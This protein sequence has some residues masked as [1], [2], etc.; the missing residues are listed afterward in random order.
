[1]M[2]SSC[3]H[4]F[5][6]QVCTMC[7]CSQLPMHYF[8]QLHHHLLFWH[9]VTSHSMPSCKPSP[10]FALQAWMDQGRSL[11]FW[12]FRHSEISSAGVACSKSCLFAKISN[13]TAASLSSARSSASSWPLSSRRRR[14][15]L[16]I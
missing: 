6:Q 5:L 4:K 3:R 11:M 1:M 7:V 8:L 16:S 13:G 10:V 15:E 14:S 9:C 12:S 2:H